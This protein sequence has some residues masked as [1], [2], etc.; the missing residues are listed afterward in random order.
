MQLAILMFY[1]IVHKLVELPLPDNIYYSFRS[2]RGN[3]H[4]FIPPGGE[5][6]VAPTRHRVTC[7]HAVQ[8]LHGV[9]W[10]DFFPPSLALF[11]FMLFVLR[12]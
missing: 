12:F 4:K 3:E 2:T 1:K 9:A 6:S 10:R 5:V 11:S 7:M 8:S